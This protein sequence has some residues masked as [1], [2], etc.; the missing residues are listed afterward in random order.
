MTVGG[1]VQMP[2]GPSFRASSFGLVQDE[3]GVVWM[4]TAPKG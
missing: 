2:P 3:F 4:V 1:Q